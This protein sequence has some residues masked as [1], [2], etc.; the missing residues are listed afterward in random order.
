MAFDRFDLYSVLELMTVAAECGDMNQLMRMNSVY[1][2]IAS[3]IYSK[4]LSDIDLE[5]EDCRTEIIDY[6]DQ[7]T[8]RQDYKEV[9]SRMRRMF[10]D[11]PIPDVTRDTRPGFL[12]ED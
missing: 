1:S 4:P 9:A 11:L 2:K 7:F 6:V 10:E 5:Y 12:S 3:S 8:S